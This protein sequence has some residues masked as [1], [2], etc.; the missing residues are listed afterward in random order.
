MIENKNHNKLYI[1]QIKWDSSNITIRE[2]YLNIKIFYIDC[3][4]DENL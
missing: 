4:N 2:K 1:S 3:H